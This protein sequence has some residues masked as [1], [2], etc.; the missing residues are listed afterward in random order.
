MLA[1]F[2]ANSPAAPQQAPAASF[3]TTK[4]LAVLQRCLT[5][6]LSQFGEVVAVK[7]EGNSTALV[8]RQ[9]QDEPMVIDLA[10]PS[11]TVT[12]NFARGTRKLVE[13]CL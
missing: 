3:Q 11:V 5:D 13:A 1:A 4:T 9:N 2:A 10:P 7:M 12:T 6:K 8:L